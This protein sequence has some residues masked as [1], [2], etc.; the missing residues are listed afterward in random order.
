MATAAAPAAAATAGLQ[1]EAPAARPFAL[2]D[3]VTTGS[4]AAAAGIQLGDQLC[5]WVIEVGGWYCATELLWL[6]VLCTQHPPLLPSFIQ[7]LT[8]MRTFPLTRSRATGLGM[9]RA[10]AAA[11][12]AA[13]C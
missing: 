9:W 7:L 4:P 11:S 3:E 5:R 10:A 6:V 12:A 13:S 2:V 1:V 8:Q